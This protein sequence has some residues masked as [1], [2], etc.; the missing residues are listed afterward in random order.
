MKHLLFTIAA[1]FAF[2][3]AFASPVTKEQAR[4]RA[5]SF[6][7]T[8]ATY[9]V[10]SKA[11]NPS[12]LTVADSSS[13]YYV[14]NVGQNGG[15]VIVSSDDR[16]ETVLGY[17]D[18]GSFNTT[19]VPEALNE[20]LLDYTNQ[21][22]ALGTSE[23]A[24]YSKSASLS[25]ENTSTTEQT[26]I[27]P[28]ITTLWG[29]NS[30]YN[31]K[32]PTINGSST[33]V[34]CVAVAVAQILNYNKWPQDSTEIIP[35]YVNNGSTLNSLP[36][37]KFNWDNMVYGSD[38]VATLMLYAGMGCKSHY[39]TYSTSSYTNYAVY[40]L[41]KYFGYDKNTRMINR[42]AYTVEEWDSIIY[43]ELKEGRPLYYSG[44]SYSGGGHAY[45]CDGYDGNGL[46]HLN[47]G[48]GS[49]YYNGYY[50]LQ[51][52][53]A[54]TN[55]YGY[56]FDQDAIIGIQSPVENE[57]D[58]PE[59]K[60]VLSN[61]SLAISGDTIFK[62]TDGTMNFKNVQVYDV[63]YNLLS[64]DYTFDAG[65]GL[66]KDDILISEVSWYKNS[67]CASGNRFTN[68]FKFDVGANLENGTYRIYPISSAAG[69][70]YW[71]KNYN[72]DDN[73]IV[74]NINDTSMVL[75][76]VE[77]ELTLTVD[78]LVVNDCIYYNDVPVNVYVSTK[79][80]PYNGDLYLFVNN[81]L[82]EGEHMPVDA[83]SSDKLVLVYSPSNS[84]TYNVNVSTDRNGKNIICSG[85]F[86]AYKSVYSGDLT[87]NV[88]LN[89]D[90]DNIIIGNTLKTSV[91]IT[92]NASSVYANT[93]CFRY[94]KDSDWYADRC[95]VI[96]QPGETKTY[97]FEVSDLPYEKS[98]L[99]YYM[100]NITTKSYTFRPVNE[101]YLNLPSQEITYVKADGTKGSVSFDKATLTV[102]EDAVAVDMTEA[103]IV[104]AVPNKNV[105]CLYYLAEDADT[106]L[107][108]DDKNVII[109]STAKSIILSD[110]CGFYIP[111]AFTA[112]K[113]SYAR[114]FTTGTNGDGEAWTT[115]NLP[116]NVTDITIDG[117]NTLSDGSEVSWFHNS[118]DYRGIFWLK[119]FVSDED[120]KVEFNYAE[121][122]DANKPYIVC[123]PQY[124]FG[125]KWNMVGKEFVFIGRNQEIAASQ[126]SVIEGNNVD[127]VGTL[128]LTKK[129][130][131]FIM[132]DVGNAFVQCDATINPFR[133]YF[134][135]KDGKTINGNL[136][137]VNL[138]LSTITDVHDIEAAESSSDEILNIYNLN[139]VKVGTT[140]KDNFN[141]SQNNLKAGIYVVNGKKIVIR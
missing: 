104:K 139:G 58:L 39:G 129:N 137:I 91:D 55:N 114:T 71:Y 102:P 116:F 17:S 21:V 13:A 135:G 94:I 36:R 115:I 87:F 66:Y 98:S 138:S 29:Q 77:P 136:D 40:E 97:S 83:N 112:K 9:D 6:L 23:S 141:I 131:V 113:I 100:G 134:V 16:T 81:N 125:V 84:G 78:S 63:V 86:N 25:S 72:S 79:D 48:W 64:N 80:K 70:N 32:C 62:R 89:T 19:D 69:L 42:N 133:A 47:F 49:S 44:C 26:A 96:L 119:E 101:A 123:V 24:N 33:V 105:N 106:P 140:T 11:D 90:E 2:T 67:F 46:Y 57:D 117:D 120:G 35:G 27:A 122:F 8:K 45:I 18:T 4:Q 68:T 15:F 95:D 34:G 60:V 124:V 14:F 99:Y 108:L 93:L 107:G 73:Y 41:L 82:V 126:E 51:T 7:S 110:T 65:L 31:R 50:R 109:G 85:K 5:L 38:E 111:I 92:N 74:A 59:E 22:D 130:N 121:T 127:F 118:I 30:P 132:N 54:N 61:T 20:L 3:A 10:G 28:L 56:S 53:R 76:L 52:C 88:K 43:N 12:D 128:S 1:I 75:H 103:T 37:Y